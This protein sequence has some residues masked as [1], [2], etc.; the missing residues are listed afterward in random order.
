[1]TSAT[2]KFIN[3]EP[4][5]PSLMGLV[6]P[7][8]KSLA[9]AQPA[10]LSWSDAIGKLNEM[11]DRIRPTTFRSDLTSLINKHSKENGSDTPD[12]LLANFLIACM[13][14]FDLTVRR[15]DEHIRPATK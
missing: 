2:D 11:P 13:D 8:E 14:A 3:G 9:V 12:Y 6:S 7:V 1:M 5:E 15:R 10:T 4:P